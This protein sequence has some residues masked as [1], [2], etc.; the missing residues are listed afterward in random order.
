MEERSLKRSYRHQRIRKKI[1]G[2]T[3][4]PRMCVFRSKKHIYAQ[5]IDDFEGKTLVSASTIEKNLKGMKGRSAC[6]GAKKIG[7]LIAERAKAKSIDNIVFDRGGYIFH[8][9]VKSL[10]DAAREKG[11]K[12]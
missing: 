7:E 5:I 6:E 1:E 9:R 10:A 4:R 8:G 2:T 11:L 12:F 3:K